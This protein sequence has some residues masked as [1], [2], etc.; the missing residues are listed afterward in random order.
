MNKLYFNLYYLYH[1]I[2]QIDLAEYYITKAFNN[3][4]TRITIIKLGLF[5]NQWNVR[6]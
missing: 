1:P 5:F 6:V 3:Q 4:N 2:Y